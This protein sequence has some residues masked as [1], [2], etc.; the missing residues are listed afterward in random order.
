[1]P[2]AASLSIGPYVTIDYEGNNFGFNYGMRYDYKNIISE[3]NYSNTDYDEQFS[4]T[5]FSSGIYF[6]L[7]DHIL[8]VS[9]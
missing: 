2:D 4:N 3:D 1:M 6:D 9:M 7:A 8:E 5:S